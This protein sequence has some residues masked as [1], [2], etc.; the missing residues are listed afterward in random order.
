MPNV[1]PSPLAGQWYPAQAQQLAKSVDAYLD[2][3]VVPP[4]PGEILGM[5]VPHAGHRY[6]GG[7]AAHAFA[8]V[9]G[10]E[11]DTVAVVGPMHQYVAGQVLTTK[12]DAY[13]TPLGEIPID[14]EGLA[15]VRAACAVP[16]TPVLGD[17]EHSVE[18]ELPFL[19]RVLG[20]FK[21][22][23]LMMRDDSAATCAAVGGA[24]ATA[25]AGR[26]C[27]LVASSDL[28]HFY[29]QRVADQL[30]AYMLAQVET[31]DPQAVLRAE[32]EEKGFACG[33]AA[34]AAVLTAAKLLGGQG[35]QIV[36]HST[37][38]DVTG[39]MK[40]VVGYGAALIWK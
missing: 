38:G 21:L 32:D 7:V 28:S 35:V 3:A 16:L 9:R 26:K 5:V 8:A 20:P 18:I 27:L 25:L 15:A 4:V 24:L 13:E 10:R 12:H 17:P 33:R 29:P 30:D 31:F 19:Q 23:P 6:S 37:S 1:R 14:I 36:K 22:I 39:D 2:A 40:S 34:I 11:F